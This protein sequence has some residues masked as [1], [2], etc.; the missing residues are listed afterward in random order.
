MMK[1]I[2]LLTNKEDITVDVIVKELKAQKK[3]YYRLNTEEIPNNISVN[4][5][6][7]RREYF[8]YDKNKRI[9]ID[10]EKVESVYF[11]RAEVNKLEYLSEVN[12]QERNYLRSELAF[13]LEGIYKILRNKFWLNNVY[14]IREAENKVF[15]LQLAQEIGFKIPDSIISNEVKKVTGMVHAFKGDCIIKPIK[16]GNMR[17]V[18]HPKVIFTEKVDIRLLEEKERIESFPSYIQ[19]NIQK[20]SDLRC[21]VVGNDVFTAQIESQTN[22]ES[23]TDWRKTKSYLEHKKHN[24]PEE[25]KNMCVLITKEMKLNYSAI[26]LIH[27]EEEQYIFLECNPN[28]QWAWIEQRLGFPIGR[29]IVKL[30]INKNCGE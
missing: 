19:Q 27:T 6:I 10:L 7:V 21:I 20:K 4:F 23:C 29:G 17:D 8:L 22:Q 1:M 11:R 2:L 26:D 24:L 13:V 30:L 18:S 14:H 25:I 3:S 15:Q 16:T 12:E 28:G 5:D 9:N